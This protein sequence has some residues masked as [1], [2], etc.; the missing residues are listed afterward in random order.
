MTT[1]ITVI[2]VIVCVFLMLTVLLQS[3]KGGGMG[4]AFG[5]GNTG[6]VFGGSGAST[7][8]R[9]LTVSA[10]VIFMMTSMLLAYLASRSSEDALRGFAASQRRQRELKEKLREEALEGTTPTTPDTGVVPEGDTATPGTGEEGK[11]EGGVDMPDPTSGSV[12]PA[13]EVPPPAKPAEPK[14]ADDQTPSPAPRATPPAAPAAPAGKTGA[15]PTGDTTAPAATKPA[16]T[17]PA[18]TKPAPPSNP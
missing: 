10:A 12:P 15:A 18:A 6:T 4:A 7:F 8:L 9:R 13:A 11:E 3:G 1:F 5:G 14:K 2:H 17:T 16:A